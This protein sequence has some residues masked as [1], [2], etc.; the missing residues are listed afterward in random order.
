ML[1]TLSVLSFV[2]SWRCRVYR[3]TDWPMIMSKL[4]KCVEAE[5]YEH[6]YE[7]IHVYIGCVHFI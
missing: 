7:Y 2:L 5:D 6:M 1:Q 3:G 4:D